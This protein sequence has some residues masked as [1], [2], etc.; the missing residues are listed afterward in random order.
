MAY[1][2]LNHALYGVVC[3]VCV[4]HKVCTSY[5]TRRS[6]RVQEREGCPVQE[7]CSAQV[8]GACLSRLSLG[9]GGRLS[10]EAARPAACFAHHR[11][12]SP[13]SPITGS[14]PFR[15][16]P[17]PASFA[18][19]RLLPLSPITGSCLFR[20][21]L[22][23]SCRLCLSRAL[24]VCGRVLCVSAGPASL[25]PSSRCL[26]RAFLSRLPLAAS[27]APSSRCLSRAFLSLPLSRLP[28]AASLAPSS[29]AFL[30][31][32]LS[33]LPLAAFL[34]PRLR[35]PSPPHPANAQHPARAPP[36][37]RPSRPADNDKPAVRADLG[38]VE[39][40]FLN[41]N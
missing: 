29:R 16:S 41:D 9:R 34:A 4:R 23:P 17:A 25:A 18:H 3:T 27:L 38:H 11:R 26:S 39:R 33:R 15:P 12:L 21:S 36:G 14:C 7:G 13:L 8:M 30:S 20:L 22:A 19:H 2:V 24:C 5:S 6:I 37:S 10:R 28:L 1:C 35:R 31:L 40:R 32:P